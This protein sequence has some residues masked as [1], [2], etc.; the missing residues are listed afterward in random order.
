MSLRFAHLL[1]FVFTIALCLTL[2]ACQPAQSSNVIR[3]TLWQGVNPPPNRDV[4]QKLVDRFNQQNPNIQVESLYVGQGDQQMPK[5]LAAVVGNAAP[6]MLWF[7]PMITGQLIELDALRSIDDLFAASPLKSELDPAL[8]NTMQFEGKAWSIPFSTNNVG[9]YY[10]PSLFASAGVKELPQTW[11]E[12][13]QVAKQLTRDTNNDGKADQYGMLLPLG[14]GEW[15]VFTWLPF[16]FSG[17][18]VLESQTGVNIANSGAIAALQFWRDLMQDGSAILS[19]PERGYELD[20]F[21]AGKVAMQLSGPWTLGQL[22]ATKVDFG[23]LPIP[24]GTQAGTAIG[25]ENLFFFKS[26][27][28][29][30]QAAFKFAEFVMSEEFQTEWAIGTGY[31]PTNLKS[32]ESQA[33]KEFRSKQPAV[34]VFLSQA[35]FGR[36]RPIFPGYNRISD[37]LGRAI[38]ATLLDQAT[39]EDALKASQQRL[40]LIFMN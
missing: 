19:Q 38:E 21:L 37:N 25:G 40:D 36:S 1:K 23:V 4:L 18:G 17:G 22:Q 3:L 33:Y 34:D 12:F 8:L 26:T 20:G 5:I 2:V 7:A 13:R 39:P 29:R 32:R 9:I 14:K 6:D 10:R 11:A 24:K 31:L 30:E 28:E 35:Q 27:P 16:M 15:T